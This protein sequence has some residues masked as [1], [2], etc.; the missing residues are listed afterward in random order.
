MYEAT[1]LTK[2]CSHTTPEGRKFAMR[3]MDDLNAHIQQ[4]KKET[5]I[6]FA[7]YGTPAE[8]LTNRFCKID[9]ARF[10]SIANVTDKDYYTNSY[11]VDVREPINSS[12]SSPSKLISKTNRR[13]AASATPKSPICLIISRPS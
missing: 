2:H 13:A 4:W 8:N 6:G 12:T 3:I 11:H 5:N 10:G 9:K 1:V 7:L